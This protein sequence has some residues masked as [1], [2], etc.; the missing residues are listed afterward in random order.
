MSPETTGPEPDADA[1]GDVDMG[2]VFDQLQELSET[3][4]T[5]TEREQVAEAMQLAAEASQTGGRSGRVIWGFDRADAAEALLGA[6]LLGIPMAVEGGTREVGTFLVVHPLY[7]V[8]SALFA[9]LLTTGVLYVAEIQDVRVK[10]RLFGLIPR[11]LAG[12]LGISALTATVMLTAW[13][14]IDWSE[15]WIALASVVVAFVP[16][17][18]GAALGDILPGS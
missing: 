6:F 18:V 7:C 4:D 8:G 1:D 15:P 16:M 12:V 5:E 2:D 17:S 10:D 13:G 3:V 11:R 9:I 14:R